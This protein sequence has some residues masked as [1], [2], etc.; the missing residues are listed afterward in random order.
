MIFF[1]TDKKSIE[2][3]KLGCHML[4][5][6][7]IEFFTKILITKTKEKKKNVGTKKAEETIFLPWM[8]RGSMKKERKQQI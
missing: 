3:T 1:I 2:R 8:S 7:S 4:W 6:K 5:A